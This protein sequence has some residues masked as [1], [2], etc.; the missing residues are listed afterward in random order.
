MSRLLFAAAQPAI[1][2]R[3]PLTDEWIRERCKQP[4]VF[5]TVKQWIREAEAAHGIVGNKQ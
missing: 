3:V 1:Q 4:W 5:E 2:E